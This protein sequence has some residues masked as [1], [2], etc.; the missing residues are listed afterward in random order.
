VAGVGFVVVATW[1]TRRATGL[2]G[3]VTV[4][5]WRAG[6]PEPIVPG[7]PRNAMIALAAANTRAAPSAN[8]PAVPIPARYARVARIALSIGTLAEN[9]R[10]KSEMSVCEH[11]PVQRRAPRSIGRDRG[12]KARMAYTALMLAAI[13]VL[14]ITLLVACGVGVVA[15]AVTIAVLVV[16]HYLGTERMIFSALGAQP[17]GPGQMPELHAAMERVCVLADRPMVRLALIDSEVPNA[18]TVARSPLNATVCVTRGLLDLLEDRELDAILAHELAHVASR[19]AVLVTLGSVWAAMAALL[20]ALD[21]RLPHRPG[22]EQQPWTAVVVLSGLLFVVS[23]VTTQALSRHRQLA[24]DRAA[25]L[26]LRGSESMGAALAMI[27]EAVD[28]LDEDGRRAVCGELTVLSIVPVDAPRTVATIFPTHPPLALRL[29]RL[30]AVGREL[31][32]PV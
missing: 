30:A 4:R 26:L 3:G 13:Y 28:Q 16:A 5:I 8:A 18:F 10:L 11:E 27:G 12:L 6:P 31:F 29:D 22:R 21:N 17:I 14:I 32:S 7:H 2:A 24:A 20:V 23:Y 19:N 1:V 9:L 25:F 15:I